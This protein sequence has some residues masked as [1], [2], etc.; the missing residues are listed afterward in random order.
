[1]GVTCAHMVPCSKRGG[2]AHEP[3]GCVLAERA[4]Q[5]GRDSGDVPAAAGQG[6]ADVLWQ[7]HQRGAPLHRHP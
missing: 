4:G 3:G 5:A 2:P 6:A 1:M 7:A